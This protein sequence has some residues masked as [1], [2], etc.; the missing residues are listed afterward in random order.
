MD[1]KVFHLHHVQHRLD[2]VVAKDLEDQE[3]LSPY[4]PKAMILSTW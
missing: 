2:K 3:D 4:Q 1:K